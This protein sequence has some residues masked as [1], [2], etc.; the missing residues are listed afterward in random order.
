MEIKFMQ[1]IAHRGG[2]SSN[3]ENSI[4]GINAIIE[5]VPSP[6]IE[7]DVV[8]TKDDVAVL[9]HEILL[10]RLCGVNIPIFDIEY[11][12]INSLQNTQPIVS[13]HEII[14]TYPNTKFLLDIKSNLHQELFDKCD[15]DLSTLDIDLPS[16]ILKSI[17]KVLTP[18]NT[19][20]FQLIVSDL[21]SFEFFKS[22][23]P[24]L[25]IDLSEIFM[26][27]F[28]ADIV[29]TGSI[30]MLN[31][32]IKRIHIQNCLLTK[33]IVDILHR[34]NIEVYSAPSFPPSFENSMKMIDKA[35]MLNV[36]GIWLSYIDAKIVSA[37]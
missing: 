7:I 36:D 18:A 5:A 16:K 34:N 9:W 4:D 22:A 3:S 26:R 24:Q 12:D 6:L 13:L 10:S 29:E 32:D 19:K 14:S 1:L 20:N 28:L 17:N 35:R 15:I 23:F 31:V 27:D 33:E 37:I 8:P 25:P 2:M 11:A 21:K 30:D